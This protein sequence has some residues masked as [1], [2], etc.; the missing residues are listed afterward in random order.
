MSVGA[1]RRADRRG[2]CRCVVMCRS[3][4]RAESRAARIGAG[5]RDRRAP[6]RDQRRSPAAM[7]G[8][9]VAVVVEMRHLARAAARARASS[10]GAR[11]QRRVEVAALRGGQQLDA[12][13]VR[14]RSRPSAAAGARRARPS[15][16]GPPGWPRSGSNR[17]WPDGRAACSPTTSAAAVTCGI[18][19]PEFSPGFG[20]RNAGRPR[21]RRVDQHGDAA[22]GERADLADRQRDHVG[23]EGHRLGVEIAAGQRLAG[24]RR[25]SAD[26]RRRRWP[27]SPS[28]VGGLAQHVEHGAHHLRLAAQAVGVLHALVADADAR[29]GWRCRPS[30]RAARRPPRSGRDGGAARGCADR[31]ARRSPWR[32]RSTARR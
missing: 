11:A 3:S 12:D 21:Q 27:R 16:R 10:G 24:R 9:E 6:L 7:S 28:V 19:K 1:A 5:G 17:R 26:C 23:G 4:V 13:H 22:L 8:C 18:M 29:R 20:V 31:T 30:A 2:R 14:R 32:R 15:R 25:R